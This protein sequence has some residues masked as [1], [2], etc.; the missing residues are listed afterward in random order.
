MDISISRKRFEY[1]SHIASA[2]SCDHSLLL[3]AAWHQH[4]AQPPTSLLSSE[5]HA[6]HDMPHHDAA[7]HSPSTWLDMHTSVADASTGSPTHMPTHK[8]L[9]RTSDDTI[10]GGR[11][12]SDMPNCV[13]I[14]WL[15]H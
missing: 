9:R 2:N 4:H 10:R 15:Y 7:S 13:E 1:R 14:P 5:L 8:A 11:K 6:F 3:W 12:P